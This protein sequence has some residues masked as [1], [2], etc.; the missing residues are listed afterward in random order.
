MAA[1]LKTDADDFTHL[2]PATGFRLSKGTEWVNTS[3]CSPL[4]SLSPFFRL[5]FIPTVNDLLKEQ[6]AQLHAFSQKT[7]TTKVRGIEPLVARP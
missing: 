2:S 5:I 4:A 3:N 6:I 7:Y 1:S